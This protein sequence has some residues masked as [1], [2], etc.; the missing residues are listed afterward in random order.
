MLIKLELFAPGPM[1][2]SD[3]L[4]NVIVTAHAFVMIFYGDSEEKISHEVF[5][6]LILNEKVPVTTSLVAVMGLPSSGK[7]TILE[8][9]FK[10]KIKLKP[11]AKFKIDYYLK[12]KRDEKCLSIY[13]L[14]ALGS[15]Q[16]SFAWSFATNRYGAIFS[17]LCGLIRRNPCVADIEFDITSQS[18]KS[19]MDKHIRWLQ[20]KT[21]ELLEGI[22]DEPGKVTLIHDGVSFINVIDVG[23]NKALYP[24][25]AM[26]L[27]H[28]H[29]HIRLAFF[30]MNRDGPN[31]DEYAELPSD[32][33]GK[34][35]DDVLVMKKRSR[36]TYLL[37]FATVGYTQQQRNQEE[38]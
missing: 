12:R 21:K 32:R 37:H 20:S 6:R 23:V 16:H 5:W 11:E 33:Y 31:L 30:S 1:L 14:C 3:Q 27:L 24:F 38:E 19:V 36:L 26:M 4:Y 22:K 10:R 29:R 9:V 7:T 28:C 35:N 34:R 15:T 25:L 2:G 18:P 13:D 17:I 8:S